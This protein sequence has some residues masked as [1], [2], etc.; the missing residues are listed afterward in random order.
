M[1]EAREMVGTHQDKG[2][3]EEEFDQ[4]RFDLE[5]EGEEEMGF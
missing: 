4:K 1:G 2:E 3:W 5:N